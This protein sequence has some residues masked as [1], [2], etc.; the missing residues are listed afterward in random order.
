[1]NICLEEA[2]QNGSDLPVTELVN[3]F[4][5]E[6]QK[7]GGGRKDTSSLIQRLPRSDAVK[8]R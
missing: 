3:R 7:A 6:I 5:T 4:Y 8:R 2:K 1:L